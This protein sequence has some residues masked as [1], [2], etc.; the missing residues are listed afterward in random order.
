MLTE[1]QLNAFHIEAKRHPFYWGTPEVSDTD[2]RLSYVDVEWFRIISEEDSQKDT[3]DHLNRVDRTLGVTERQGLGWHDS[4]GSI[5]R[6]GEEAYRKERRFIEEINRIISLI[7]VAFPDDLSVKGIKDLAQSLG[8]G[9]ANGNPTGDNP[10]TDPVDETTSPVTASDNQGGVDVKQEE[11]DG[12][13]D[14]TI[15]GVSLQDAAAIIREN[16]PEGQKKIVR[17]WQGSRTPKLPA[18]IGKA[19][20]HSQRNLYEPTA[21]LE[22]LKKIEGDGIENDFK[23]LRYFQRVKRNRKQ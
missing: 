18:P 4:S 5:T 11:R 7:K 8:D 15:Q 9:L 16:D 17:S 22:F 23:V 6:E 19:P 13:E 2:E 10:Q 3:R 21:L 12:V 1:L 20:E 14:A